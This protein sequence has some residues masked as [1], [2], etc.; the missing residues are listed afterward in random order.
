MELSE[1]KLTDTTI[2]SIKTLDNIRKMTLLILL[3]FF[4]EK[5][6]PYTL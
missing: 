4:I 2:S 1:E 3:E 6:L 5:V